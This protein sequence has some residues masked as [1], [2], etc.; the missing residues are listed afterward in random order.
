MLKPKTVFLLAV[1]AAIAWS[2]RATTVVV[3]TFN[4]AVNGN[5]SSLT[6]LI[7]NPGPDGI[8]L[9]EAIMAA[10]NS[11]GANTIRVPPGT[12]YLTNASDGELEFGNGP[13]T[14]TNLTILPEEFGSE[15]QIV[16]TLAGRRVFNLDPG[17]WGGVS[18]VISG[19]TISGGT[20]TT[21]GG[22]GILAGTTGDSTVVSNCVIMGN[23]TDGTNQGG[24]LA[25]GGGGDLTVVGCVFSNNVSDL[26]GGALAYNNTTHPGNL[27]ISN[28][29]FISNECANPLAAQG[30][31]VYI[32][33]VGTFLVE[34]CT[35]QDNIAATETTNAFGGAIELDGGALTV[36][37]SRFV[38]NETVD[39]L[40]IYTQAGATNDAQANWWGELVG[41]GQPPAG[42]VTGLGQN[43]DGNSISF[44]LTSSVSFITLTDS[45]GPHSATL[46][47][48]FQLNGAQLTGAQLPAFT[49]VPVLWDSSGFSATGAD[50]SA[51][52][53]EEAPATP[54]TINAA[55]MVDNATISLNLAVD[56]LA[57][58]Q[59]PL[60]QAACESN[61]V[62]FTSAAAA[63]PAAT[64]QWQVSTNNGASWS[65]LLGATTDSLE[66]DALPSATNLY[67]AE[68]TS[69]VGTVDSSNATLIVLLDPIAGPAVFGTQQSASL[70]T[71]IASILAADSDPSGYALSISSVSSTSTNGGTVTEANGSITYTPVSGFSGRDQYTYTLENSVSCPVTG[72]VVLVVTPPGAPAYDNVSLALESGGRELNFTGVP[73]QSYYLQSSTVVSGPYD[74][75]SQPVVASS[76]GAVQFFDNTPASATEFYRVVAAQ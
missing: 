7:N 75:M 31:A 3:S 72:T 73:G 69:V 67:R 74:T 49:N 32:N 14:G 39:G 45:P 51:K 29:T 4:D 63:S 62:D 48:M 54:G 68:F 58:T 15:V 13:F 1:A 61:L 38:A 52:L 60:S 56:E 70:T 53:V 44:A 37:Y 33:G 34:G 35:F 65:A 40:A 41:S 36:L 28:C 76:T 16:Q 19:L 11:S 66:V 9:R 27:V 23:Q 30:G 22:G 46:T 8:S 21:F 59:E 17:Q 47:G 12:Y 57:I 18:V 26:I 55:I 50:G 5:D 6:A 43:T 2:A 10:N 24:G 42:M 64:V 71:P 20:G 25:Y